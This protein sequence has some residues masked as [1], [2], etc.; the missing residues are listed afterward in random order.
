MSSSYLEIKS[1]NEECSSISFMVHPTKEYFVVSGYNSLLQNC[2][3]ELSALYFTTIKITAESLIGNLIGC[4]E[5]SKHFCG[6]VIPLPALTVL[7]ES[8]LTA[9]SIRGFLGVAGCLL[10]VSVIENPVNAKSMIASGRN[11]LGTSIEV[12]GQRAVLCVA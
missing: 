7:A 4:E 9:E 6:Y 8:S 12:S 1:L 3:T 5:G 11:A 2:F 10:K